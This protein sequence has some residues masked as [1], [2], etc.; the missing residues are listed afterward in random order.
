VDF[1]KLKNKLKKLNAILAALKRGESLQNR[2]LVTWLNQEEYENFES[3]WESQQQIR[4]ELKDKSDELRRYDNKLHQATFNDNKVERF[5][6]RG[7]NDNSIKFRNT[8]ESLC[9]EALEILQ[10]I[11]D[12]DTSFHIWFDR[13]LNFGHGSLVSS[14][15][16]N[17]SRVVQ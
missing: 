14:Q 9:E 12:V 13:T 1:L 3:D 16:G 11:V 8:S 10:E 7:N 6:K 5:R 4:E 15:L 17:L 2:Q